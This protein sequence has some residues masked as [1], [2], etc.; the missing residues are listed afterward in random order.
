MAGRFCFDVDWYDGHAQII[1]SYNL[2]LFP[3]DGCVEMYDIKNRRTFLKKTKADVFV[4]QLRPGN[5]VTILSRQL[6]VRDYGDDYTRTHLAQQMQKTLLIVQGSAIQHFGSILDDL[7]SKDFTLSRL[8][9]MAPSAAIGSIVSSQTPSKQVI[10]TELVRADAVQLTMNIVAESRKRLGISDGSVHVSMSVEAAG[11][12]LEDV[13]S[14]KSMRQLPRTAKFANCALALIKPHAVLSGLTGKIFNAIIKNGFEIS[15]MELFN[16]EK[17]NAEEFL[18]VY[19]G[20][21]PDYHHIVEHISSGPLVAM[22]ITSSS[23]TVVSDFRE[24]CGP[25]DPQLAKQLRPESLRAKYGK[26]KIQN[27][28]HCTDLTED[29]VLEVS[30]FFR[31]LAL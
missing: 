16:L 31:I 11:K 8:R 13:F 29:G 19:K 15:D 21:T 3:A 1:R 7:L 14:E 26:D 25:S 23:K 22:E 5:A 18:E 24:F 17:T 28:L 20:V 27:A 2:F 12:E 30:Y 6:I 9:M 10:V 4:E